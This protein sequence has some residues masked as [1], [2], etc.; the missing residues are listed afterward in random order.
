M[1]TFYWATSRPADRKT[2]NRLILLTFIIATTTTGQFQRLDIE[3][4]PF[5]LPITSGVE[6]DP[7]RRAGVAINQIPLEARYDLFSLGVYLDKL[8]PNLPATGYL[9]S[10]D[11]HGA[12]L[13]AFGERIKGEY[14][15]CIR[16][17]NEEFYQ[18]CLKAW[19]S[20]EPFNFP[21]E[22]PP[23]FSTFITFAA[24]QE[25]F[26][27]T[28]DA[29]YFLNMTYEAEI[30]TQAICVALIGPLEAC[31]VTFPFYE[32]EGCGLQ[33]AIHYSTNYR[34]LK[35]ELEA[36]QCAA[37]G[38]EEPEDFKETPVYCFGRDGFRVEDGLIVH[39]AATDSAT[40]PTA[41]SSAP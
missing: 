1:L 32:E 40:S 14:M 29:R 10:R 3:S 16:V 21:S 18:D 36:I 31:L 24:Y 4:E 34:P 27:L 12:I 35:A 28:I 6:P 41:P 17:R 11:D 23:E 22:G 25:Q 30:S 13:D 26:W 5:E 33:A 7:A 39:E 8:R 20:V 19:R 15:L 38:V 37:A 9:M 2:T